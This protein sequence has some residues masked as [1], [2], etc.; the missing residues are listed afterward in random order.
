MKRTILLAGLL[1]SATLA[2]AGN[3]TLKWAKAINEVFGD[4]LKLTAVAL[5]YDAPIDSTSLTLKTYTVRG[6]EVARVYTNDRA[7]KSAVSKRGRYVLIALKSPIALPSKRASAAKLIGAA[8]VVQKAKIKVLGGG[9]VKALRDTIYTLSTQNIAVDDFKQQTYKDR[10]TGLGLRYNIFI[11]R[12]FEPGVKYPLVLFLHDASGVGKELK[13]PLVQGNGATVWASPEWQE[14]HP[15]VVVAPQFDR[16]TADDTY[17]Y[18]DE[19]RAC[20][21]L[22][23]FLKK[24]YPLDADRLYVTGQGMGAMSAYVMLL[25]RPDLFASALLVSGHWDARKLGPLA[26]K[27]LWLVS[28]KKDTKTI[29]G[30][31]KMLDEWDEHDAMVSEKDWPLEA[32][33]AERA[34]E[35]HELMLTGSNIKH[36]RLVGGDGK[37]A[38]R[39]AYSIPGMGEWLFDQ[40]LSKNI[41]ELRAHLLNV[42][43]KEVLLDAHRGDW[44]GTSENS[45]N[46]VFKSVER[47]RQMVSVDVRKT[48]DGQ[49]VCFSDRTLERLTNGKGLVGNKTLAELKALK[50]KDD[51]GQVTKWVMPTLKEVLNYAKGRILVDINAPDALLSDIRDVVAEAG[52]Q[53][54]AILPG[55]VKDEGNWMHKAVVDLDAP[56]AILRVRKALKSWPVMVELRFSKNNNS[57]LKHA[58]SLVR[59]HA[60][61]CFNTTEKGLAGNHVDVEKDGD[62]ELVWGDLIRQGGTIIKT[63]R[64][65]R[66]VEY[67]SK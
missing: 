32:T 62:A 39:V 48:K 10:S 20:Q 56:R 40:R 65:E 24:Q 59:G 25:R 18:G 5:E 13:N 64:P 26:K 58:I 12:K 54:V 17:H 27:N 22:V 6:G 23:D 63:N 53:S 9:K 49:L 43:G 46:A 44:H 47:G 2:N 8:A 14:K 15:C 67:L 35:V 16:L 4:G 38:W 36:T 57:L 34:A 19:I 11:P 1:V 66:L 29:A 30:V 7:E 21:S 52:A 28:G 51:R 45:L 55:A 3:H 60:R 37:D 42:T 41:D 31:D 33:A 61:V 50:M